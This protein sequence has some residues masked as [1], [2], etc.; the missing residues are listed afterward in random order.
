MSRHPVQ[1]QIYT[2]SDNVYTQ[3]QM[4]FR[5]E[6]E[7]RKGAEGRGGESNGTAAAYMQK[8]LSALLHVTATIYGRGPTVIH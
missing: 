1:K 2:Q 8:W 3:C 7:A 4:V 5:V 6:S